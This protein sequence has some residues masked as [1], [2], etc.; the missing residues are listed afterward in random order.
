MSDSV[1]V[2]PRPYKSRHHLLVP[3]RYCRS[4]KGWTE[5]EIAADYLRWFNEQTR[6]KLEPG[7]KRLLLLDG[8]VSHFSKAFIERAIELDIIVL[9][10]PPHSTHLLQGLDVVLFSHAKAEWTKSRD[11]WERETGEVVTK[12]TFLKV[13]GE[14]YLVAFTPENNKKAFAKTGVHPYNRSVIKPKDLAPSLEH[15]KHAT[16]PLEVPQDVEDAIQLYREAYGDIE[17]K[18]DADEGWVTD[19]DGDNDSDSDEEDLATSEHA[20]LYSNQSSFSQQHEVSASTKSRKSSQD[21]HRGQTQHLYTTPARCRFFKSLENS[22]LC[23]DLTNTS[24]SCP[25]KK[26]PKRHHLHPTTHVD[27]ASLPRPARSAADEA[28]I[29]VIYSCLPGDAMKSMPSAC[30]LLTHSWHWQGC[31]PKHVES[32]LQPLLGRKRGQRG[33]A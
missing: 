5:N 31:M 32:M 13:F 12:E 19:S 25:P 21:A 27:W 23:Q 11:R 10:Y 2:S 26:L 30:R 6:F 16:L 8:H 33:V 18:R 22:N 29:S 14:S 17:R 1:N 7:E 4:E 9:C 15:S 3:N 24:P 20:L 28:D